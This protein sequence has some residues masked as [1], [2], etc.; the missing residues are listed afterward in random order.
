VNHFA[1]L[2]VYQR[3][4]LYVALAGGCVIG[5]TNTAEDAELPALVKGTLGPEAVRMETKWRDLETKIG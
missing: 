2:F 3:Y 1:S 4:W 5:L